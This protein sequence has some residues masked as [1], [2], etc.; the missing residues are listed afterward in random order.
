MG[1]HYIIFILLLDIEIFY[2]IFLD[3]TFSITEGLFEAANLMWLMLS[4]SFSMLCVCRMATSYSLFAINA[5][6][7]CVLQR[8][9]S[10]S[11]MDG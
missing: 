11:S 1:R 4:E 3:D 5:G 8:R 10:Q 9:M 2:I 6:F 7:P